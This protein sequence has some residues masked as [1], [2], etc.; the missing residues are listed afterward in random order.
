MLS[1]I[2]PISLLQLR[3]I[4]DRK[5]IIVQARESIVLAVVQIH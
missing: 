2:T 1:L 3:I 4:Y 5:K